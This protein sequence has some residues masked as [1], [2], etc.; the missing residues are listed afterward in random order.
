MKMT[1]EESI[2]AIKHGAIAGFLIFG[3]TAISSIVLMFKD[4]NSGP[5]SFLNDPYVLIGSLPYLLCSIGLLYKS[6]IAAVL[7]LILFVADKIMMFSAS[8]N[9][10]GTAFLVAI[11]F[12]S[13]L[14]KAAYGTYV[15]HRV[16]INSD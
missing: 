16:E 2:K 6:R 15:Y 11:G 7:I 1:R 4:I 3:I 12:I 8:E 9:L 13:L 14:A 5:L 10:E